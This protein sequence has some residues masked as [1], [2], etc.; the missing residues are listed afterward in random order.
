LALI[1]FLISPTVLPVVP[2][3]FIDRGNVI[4]KFRQKDDAIVWSFIFGLGSAP[5]CYVVH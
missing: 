2:S 3:E 4:P 5:R 1:V